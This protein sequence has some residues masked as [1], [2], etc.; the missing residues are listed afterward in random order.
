MP[1]KRGRLEWLRQHIRLLVL[2]ADMMDAYLFGVDIRAEVMILDMH[3]FGAGAVFMLTCHFQSTNVVLEDL[4]VNACA[5]CLG[6][7]GVA[8]HFIEEVHHWYGLSQSR[9]EANIFRFAAAEGDMRLE[10]ALPAYWAASVCDAVSMTR[11]C[12]I[13]IIDVCM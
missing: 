6:D 10:L 4:A 13:N 12:G 1:T 2:R 5:W 7:K 9:T 8:M 3:V 11:F